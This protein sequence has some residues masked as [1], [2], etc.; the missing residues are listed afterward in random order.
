MNYN[1]Y[2]ERRI[3]NNKI[4]RKR[5]LQQKLLLFI[6]TLLLSIGI[7]IVFF[8]ITSKAETNDSIRTYKYYKSIVVNSGD[9]LTD[10]AHEY[11]DLN[12]TNPSDYIAE[13][14]NM[15]HLIDENITSGMCL[16]IPYYSTT[17]ME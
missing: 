13:I 14:V 17:F 16:I 8:G 6:T 9:T 10:Y 12:E 1:N 11:A 5:E 15:N 4:R 7:S 2:S 3:R